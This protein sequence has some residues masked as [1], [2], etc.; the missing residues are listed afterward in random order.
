MGKF[1]EKISNYTGKLKSVMIERV[2]PGDR[3]KR[4]YV[5]ASNSDLVLVQHFHDFYCEGFSVIRME[6]V[7]D[8]RSDDHERFF[9]KIRAAEG[10]L[11]QVEYDRHLPLD[12]FKA[13]LSAFVGKQE[14]VIIECETM[15][16]EKDDFYLGVITE[17]K[18]SAVWML[19]L[20]A[21]GVWDDEETGI[22]LD[23]ITQVQ[24]E[25]PYIKML[26]KY[27]GQ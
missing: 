26:A 27:A 13:L 2:F 19:E 17:I 8:F 21:L 11:S 20:D 12:N 7:S 23:R 6:D 1:M 14:I 18:D 4:C 3:D 15:E 9:D 16:S 5:H 22:E 24:F 25:T 10:M